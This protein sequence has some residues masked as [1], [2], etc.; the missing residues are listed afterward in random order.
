MTV[1]S[2]SSRLEY[3]GNGVTVAFSVTFQFLTSTDLKVYQA[4]TL[5]TI[6]THYTVTGGNGATGTVTFVTAPANAEDV[7]I[8]N[9][10][11]MTQTTDYVANDPFPAESHE[12]ALDKLTILIQ[13]VNDT[14]SRSFTLADG[15]VSTASLVI[16]EPESEKV[17]AWNTAADAL[18]YKSL[19]ALGVISIPVTVAQGGTNATTAA[20]ARAN[21]GAGAIGGNVFTAATAAAAQQAMDVEVGVDVQAYDANTAKLNVDQSWTGAQR[22][23]VTT[24]NDLSFD[25]SASNNFSCTPSA[26]G[27]LTFTNHTA[28]QSGMILLVNGSNYAISAA[29]TTKITAADLATIST[30]GTYLISYFDNGTN[31]YCVCSGNVA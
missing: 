11:P 20:D 25:Q 29:A 16:P 9:D 5:K 6:S 10:P 23:T 26:G 13:R 1:S 2:T 21:L 15:S 28:G 7:V 4:G 27:T 24:D 17:I 19:T 18:E 22:G 30:T 14:L 8:V 12:R 31:A 3:T